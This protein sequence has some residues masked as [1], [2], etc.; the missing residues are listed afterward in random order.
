[1]RRSGELTRFTRLA[2][3]G[4]SGV[5]I[6]LGAYWLL[7]RFAGINNY[8]ALAA[9]FE[10]S[11]V[12]DFVLNRFFTFS[13]RRSAKALPFPVQFV[14]FNIISLGGLGI[15]EGSLWLFNTVIG[16]HDVIAVG[17]GIVIAALLDNFLNSWFTWK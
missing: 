3:V 14:K 9:G 1:M 11:V 17:I 12:S 16:L 8:L 10:A 13:N 7:T 15:Q 2:L 5:V 6:N 4:L